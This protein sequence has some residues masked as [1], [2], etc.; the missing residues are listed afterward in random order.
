MDSLPCAN[1]QKV[2]LNHL[3]WFLKTSPHYSH[4][5][6]NVRVVNAQFPLQSNNYDC[7]CFLVNNA[8]RQGTI[9]EIRIVLMVRIISQGNNSGYSVA[10]TCVECW[11]FHYCSKT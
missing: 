9:E 6:A 10:I 5:A 7:C 1:R 11:L 2:V 8:K 3:L 4:L